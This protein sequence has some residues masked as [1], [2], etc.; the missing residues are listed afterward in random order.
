MRTMLGCIGIL[1]A[2]VAVWWALFYL[3]WVLIR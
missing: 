3:V 1:V 2:V